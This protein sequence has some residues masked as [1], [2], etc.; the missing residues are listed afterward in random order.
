[1]PVE[2]T[3]PNVRANAIIENATHFNSRTEVNE[4]IHLFETKEKKKDINWY[5]GASIVATMGTTALSLAPSLINL[6]GN[7]LKE[8]VSPGHAQ[9]PQ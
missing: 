7:C 3:H 9:H 4:T 8:N 6:I 1:M 2:R 5:T